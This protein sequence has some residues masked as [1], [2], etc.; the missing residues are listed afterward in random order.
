MNSQKA[1][2][3]DI[4]TL[5]MEVRIWQL[6]EQRVTVNQIVKDWSVASWAAKW[7]NTPASEIMYKD[8][9]LNSNVR[10]DKNILKPLWNLLDEANILVTQNGKNFDSRKLNA[11]FIEYG[12]KPPSPYEHLDTYKIA[13]SVAEFTSHKLEY[14]TEKLNVKYKKLSHKKYPGNSLWDECLAGNKDAWREMKRYN[15]HDVLA[16]EE[17]YLNLQAWAPKSAPRVFISPNILICGVCG[18]NAIAGNGIRFTKTKRYQRLRCNA[19]GHHSIGDII[20]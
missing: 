10:N 2:V 18:K 17:L 12:M 1:L 6:G 13:D 16:T 8:T 3:L 19:C 7:L 5:P 14:L 15:I 4:E 9:S 20:K 11:R